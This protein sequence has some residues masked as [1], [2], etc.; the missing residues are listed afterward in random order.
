MF[1]NS[2]SICS[3]E[4]HNFV[5]TYN[6]PKNLDINDQF[7]SWLRRSNKQMRSGYQ[8]KHIYE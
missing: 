1:F 4:R 2:R 6:T 3:F 8:R 7:L 5:I